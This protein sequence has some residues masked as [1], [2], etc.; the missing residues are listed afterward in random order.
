MLVAFGGVLIV[1]ALKWPF[2]RQAVTKNLQ[3]VS[4]S[5]VSIGEFREYFWPQPGYWAKSVSFSRKS[6]KPFA[7]I[8]KI[9][10]Q[11]S[12]LDILTFTH[13][14]KRADLSG[15]RVALPEHLPPPTKAPDESAIM[16]TVEELHADGTVLTIARPNKTLK[17]DFAKLLLGSLAANKPINYDLALTSSTPGAHIL[18]Q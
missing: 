10:G 15:L 5:N 2:T 1:L 17:F 9:S 13:R 14:V 16:T 12:W 4:R 18:A 11:A 7:T 3:H 6:A 8:E